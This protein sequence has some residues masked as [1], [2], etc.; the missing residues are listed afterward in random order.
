M[1][2]S[3][4]E[5]SWYVTSVQSQ[6]GVK[7]KISDGIIQVMMLDGKHPTC[8]DTT[9]SENMLYRKI[10]RLIIQGNN[11]ND[12]DE[13]SL[14]SDMRQFSICGNNETNEFDVY[15]KAE[16]RAMEM[17][18]AHGEHARRHSAADYYAT[19]ILS[20]APFISTIHLIK[21]TMQLLE[22]YLLKQV[23]DFKVPSKSWVSLQFG[24]ISVS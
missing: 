5:T 20:H 8:A 13:L 4:Q 14:I 21:S 12:E 15:W 24:E 6:T 9:V 23:V 10:Q 1:S 18:S 19:N 16:I 3:R 17:E 11:F 22:K 7:K 2:L